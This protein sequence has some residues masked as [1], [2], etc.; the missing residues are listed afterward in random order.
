[1]EPMPPALMHRVLT[2]GWPGK[3][4]WAQFKKKC[5]GRK[6]NK[7][8]FTGGFKDYIYL[9]PQDSQARFFLKNEVC[10]PYIK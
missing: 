5:T 9:N 2:T 8:S 4:L 10:L 6:K 3:S 7:K 1:M